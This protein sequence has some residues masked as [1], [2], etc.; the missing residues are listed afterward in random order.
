MYVHI[1]SLGRRLVFLF[2]SCTLTLCTSLR[3]ALLLTPL[4]NRFKIS[5]HSVSVY[6]SLY[7]LTHYDHQPGS[8]DS[9][10]LTPLRPSYH[11]HHHD[12]Q[13]HRLAFTAKFHGSSHFLFLRFA[14]IHHH[15]HRNGHDGRWT[16]ERNRIINAR[17][18]DE[19]LTIDTIGWHPR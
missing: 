5:T 1:H 2:C 13:R 17:A 6:H 9:L 12:H 19:S 14:D 15:H 18:L 11:R 4:S 16:C 7:K 8:H 10:I 3:T